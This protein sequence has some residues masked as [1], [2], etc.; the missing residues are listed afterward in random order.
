[1]HDVVKTSATAASAACDRK[2]IPDDLCKKMLTAY[3][4]FQLSWPVVDD[5]WLT[6]SKAPATDSGATAA[7][8]AAHTVFT[9]DY[10]SIMTLLSQ[11]GVIKAGGTP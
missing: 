9:N 10:N 4:T 6:Y 8:N 11:T 5:A 7:F 3:K 2:A 1:M